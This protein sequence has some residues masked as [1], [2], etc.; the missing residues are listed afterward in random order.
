LDFAVT[1]KAAGTDGKLQEASGTAKLALTLKKK[2][3][4]FASPALK[5]G[6]EKMPWGGTKWTILVS[7]PPDGPDEP[8]GV[9]VTFYTG[10]PG[11]NPTAAP[12]RVD[13]FASPAQARILEPVGDG[14]MPQGLAVAAGSLSLTSFDPAKGGEIK[15]RL[16]GELFIS[17]K[18][19]K[20]R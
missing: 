18:P 19:R 8:A 9:E 4:P 15:G 1:P 10:I 11:E 7:R 12:M 17:D 3:V 14:V 6:S 5:V 16:T 2:P 20:A 13:A